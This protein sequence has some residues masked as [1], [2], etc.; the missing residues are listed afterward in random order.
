M[1][2]KLESTLV[3]V[4][5]EY[6][7]AG[8]LSL[9]GY[10]A[11]M[12]LRNSRGIDIIASN[13][14]GSKSISVQ[15]KTNSSGGKAWMLNKKS[16]DFFSENHYYILVALKSISERPDFHIVPSKVVAEY[17]KRTH[18]NWLRGKKRDGSERKDST[19]RKF[20]D[21]ENEYLEAWHLIKL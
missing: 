10:L 16:E 18:I 3:G 6:L 5:G 21:V 19:L 20:R 4:A 13:S 1:S 17:V 15:V 9:R 14:D 12:T 7:V 11:S 2:Q 8:E